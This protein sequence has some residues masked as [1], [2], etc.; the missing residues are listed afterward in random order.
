MVPLQLAQRRALAQPEQEPVPVQELVRLEPQHRFALGLP[1]PHVL[2]P[3]REQRLAFP[4]VH[5]VAASA[6]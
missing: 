2:R 4:Q 3:E 1:E 5:P 6:T